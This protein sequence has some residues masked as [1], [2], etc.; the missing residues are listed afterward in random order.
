MLRKIGR[1]P[2]SEPAQEAFGVIRVE[3]VRRMG[4]QEPLSLSLVVS[5]SALVLF[6]PV[7]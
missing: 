1:S 5:I 4:H 7:D 2:R 6:Q 3:C